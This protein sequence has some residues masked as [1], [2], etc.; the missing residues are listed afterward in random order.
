MRRR[1]KVCSVVMSCV[2][3]FTSSAEH[4][5]PIPSMEEVGNEADAGAGNQ[6]GM[7]PQDQVIVPFANETMH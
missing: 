6:A 5:I 2:L 4:K 1:S 3:S 7:G